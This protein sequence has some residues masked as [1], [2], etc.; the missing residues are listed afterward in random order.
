MYHYESYSSADSKV[1]ERL[2]KRCTIERRRVQALYFWLHIDFDETQALFD[3]ESEREQVVLAQGALLLSHYS[4]NLERHSNTFWLSVA[5]RSAKEYGAHLYECDAN[6][7]KYERQMK[8]RLWW[9]CVLRDRILH[10]GLRRPLQIDCLYTSDKGLN[11]DDFDQDMGNSKVYDAGTQ[12]LLAKILVAQTRLAVEMTDAIT[13]LYPPD[14]SLH[15]PLTC[16]ET[17]DRVSLESD[18]CNAKLTAW[19]EDVH[20]WVS[21]FP[22]GCH[23]SVSLYSS[24][25]YIYYQCVQLPHFTGKVLTY[26]STARLALCNHRL[27]LALWSTSEDQSHIRHLDTVCGEVRASAAAVIY[28]VQDLLSLN[29]AKHLPIS[30]CVFYCPLL[31][32]FT[33]CAKA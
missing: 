2:E 14:G 10:L 23:A 25:M 27:A 1:F 9:S 32:N 3:L 12:R 4:S 8:K 26:M 33:N 11:D 15:I 17:L 5:I 6:L 31:T 22:K 13:I 7:T 18:R 21:G 30:A 20:S 24:L 29:I 19:F 16:Q 28:I